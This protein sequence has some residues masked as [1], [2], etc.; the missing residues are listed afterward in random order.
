MRL[1]SVCVNSKTKARKIKNIGK[2]MRF[3]I[4]D[5][6]RVEAKSELKEALCPVCS[7][8]VIAKCGKQRI[9]HW[10]HRTNKTCDSW[11]ESETEWHRSWKNNFS[12][13]W[14]EVCLTDEQTG[15]KHI[16]DVCINNGIVIEFQHSHLDAK[17]RVMREQ[18]YKNMIW[19]VDGTRLKRDYSRFI[20]GNQ[21]YFKS[22]N[23][24]G[25]FLVNFPDKCFSREWIESSVPV[26]F[27]FRG[28]VSATEPQDV[29][30]D[31]LWCI[32][33]GRLGNSMVVIAISRIDFIPAILNN[34]QLFQNIINNIRQANTQPR[35]IRL[36]VNVYRRYR[37]SL[38]DNMQYQQRRYKHK[39]RRRF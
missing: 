24:Q 38:I 33:P 37:G 34:P 25:Y 32:L 17:E 28:S 7:K 23:T 30:R 19:V 8:P 39:A 1:E 4:I 5:N 29:I 12:V 26:L 9:H 31:T 2:I 22:T 21:D 18:F 35:M 3:A 11:W 14:Q 6:N 10:A 27:D 16:A 15:E 13:E 36:P 20:K